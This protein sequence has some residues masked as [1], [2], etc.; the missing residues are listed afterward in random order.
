MNYIEFIKHRNLTVI[1]KG[2]NMSWLKKKKKR[3]WFKLDAMLWD[4]SF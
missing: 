3:M 2:D 1:L 4:L